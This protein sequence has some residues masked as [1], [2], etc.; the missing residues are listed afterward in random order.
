MG[1]EGKYSSE[2]ILEPNINSD[3][4]KYN[5]TKEY[6][7]KSVLNSNGLKNAVLVIKSNSKNA[8]STAINIDL[9]SDSVK[10][11]ASI[12]ELVP[13]AKYQFEY[14]D[15]TFVLYN[16]GT[17]SSAFEFS[18]ISDKIEFTTQTE[19]IDAGDS[20]VFNI[21]FKDLPIND[22]VIIDTLSITSDLC[23]ESLKIPCKISI[24]KPEIVR[25][26]LSNKNC[27]VGEVITLNMKIENLQYP[28]VFKMDSLEIYL[29]YNSSVLSLRNKLNN[30]LADT[31]LS[32]LKIGIDESKNELN[33][34]LKFDTGLGNTKST[35]IFI[36]DVQYKGQKI[37]FYSEPALIS[38]IGICSEGG[39][40]LLSN[41]KLQNLQ[42]IPS[43]VNSIAKLVIPNTDIESSKI[44]IYNSLGE[45]ILNITPKSNITEYKIDFS[46]FPN[47][48]YYVE[49]LNK[50]TK[51]CKQIEVCR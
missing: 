33:E 19:L 25:I 43:P 9:Y 34:L 24:K 22:T 26:G 42:I 46:A 29:K 15:T 35:E 28:K 23:G 18:N 6:I 3:I 11:Q 40:R 37:D 13:D 4:I 30:N 32:I 48:I 36:T 45:N 7:I 51:L 27:Y 14:Q 49:Y 20:I 47:G 17:I 5:Q 44:L 38:F 21:H 39:D 50:D 8:D 2:F 10:Y 1:I 16:L 31:T 12:K 41:T